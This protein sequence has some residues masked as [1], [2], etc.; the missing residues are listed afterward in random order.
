MQPK[1][2]SPA[3]LVSLIPRTDLNISAHL[4]KAWSSHR[5]SHVDIGLN[6]LEEGVVGLLVADAVPD[7]PHHQAAPCTPPQG[8]CSTG[9]K[10]VFTREEATHQ[11]VFGHD[12][13]SAWLIFVTRWLSSAKYVPGRTMHWLGHIVAA[14]EPLNTEIARSTAAYRRGCVHW[15]CASGG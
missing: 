1:P 11:P 3:A 4:G 10:H 12:G 9:A 7:A 13:T 8:P 2:V 15:V 6:L 14:P 5:A